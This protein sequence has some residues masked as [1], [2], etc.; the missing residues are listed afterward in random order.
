MFI[1]VG[2]TGV[3]I[4]WCAFIHTIDMTRLALGSRV[5]SRKREAGT[6]VVKIHIRPFCGFMACA[7]IRS[8]LAVMIILVG[9]AGITIRWRALVNSIGVT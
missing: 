2:M 8:K 9:M 6:V 4:R 1:L 5:P 7:A 3:T